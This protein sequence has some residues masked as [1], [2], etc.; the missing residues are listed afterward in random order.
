LRLRARVAIVLAIGIVLTLA[1]SCPTAVWAQLPT[2]QTRESPARGQVEQLVRQTGAQVAVAFRSL[3]SS[4]ELFL[5]ADEPFPTGPATIQV[6]I[7]MELYS[8]AQT[9]ALHLSDT[10]IVRNSFHS[11][12]DNSTYQLDPKTDPDPA[13][14]NSMGKPVT[15][16]QLCEDMVAK[17]STLAAD[18]LVEKLGVARIRQRIEALH[19]NGMEL[20]R[21]FEPGRQ[22]DTKPENQTTARA[23]FE[24]LWTLAKG[25]EA[26]DDS[27]KQMIGMMARAAFSHAPT[28]GMPSDPRTAESVS[29]V[30]T[31]Q[32]ALIV[33]GPHPYVIVIL[34]RGISN[35][36]AQAEL[37]AQITHALSAAMT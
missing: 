4:Q 33:E 12:V 36:E 31:S 13:L 9:G 11:L 21:G 2:G 37:M 35:P 34:V 25:Q 30:E 7:M 27:S 29:L 26:D 15:L 17:N 22:L 14:Y 20:F 3:D 8:E 5:R 23:V 24:L 10:V 28:A 19:A 6:P 1:V 32:Q 18:L 16:Q